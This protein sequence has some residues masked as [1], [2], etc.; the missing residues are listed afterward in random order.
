MFPNGSASRSTILIAP[1]GHSP[2]QAPRPSQYV[3]ATSRALPSTMRSAPSAHAGTHR[4]QP[5]HFVSSILMSFLRGSTWFLFSADAI[6][7]M[8]YGED[9]VATEHSRT[10]IPHHVLDLSPHRGLVAMHGAV[11]AGGLLCTKRTTL[12]PT[13]R[14]RQDLL[15]FIAEGI[16]GA[17]LCPAVDADHGGNGAS[18]PHEPMMWPMAVLIHSR[19][20]GVDAPK[21]QP[22]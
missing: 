17:V 12:K 10:G 13:I 9:R 2:R 20:A 6:P 16:I 7:D 22:L 18:F 19:L 5:S 11:S 3:S 8:P 4:P 21:L 14:I 15:T 1:R